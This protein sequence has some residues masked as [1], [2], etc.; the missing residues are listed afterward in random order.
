MIAQGQRGDRL[1]RGIIRSFLGFAAATAALSA[2]PALAQRQVADA[3]DPWVHAPTGTR[4]P[5]TIEGFER[6]R[7]TEYSEDGRDASVGYTMRRGD[8]WVTVTLYVYPSIADWDCQTTFAD[9]KR[10]IENHKGAQLVSEGLGPAPS[11]RGGPAAFH[12]RYSLP[13]GAMGERVPAVRS[14]AYLYCP[15]G[16][17]WLVKYRATWGA[18]GDFSKEVETLLRA[19]AWPKKLG[20]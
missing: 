9:V 11:G 2:A 14:D 3:S 15:A 18:E 20:G 17:E 13:A 6:G 12:A 16:G 5:A 10:N 1:V 8:E 4:F 7:V 19:I